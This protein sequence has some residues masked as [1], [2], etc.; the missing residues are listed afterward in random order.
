MRDK[1]KNY[2]YFK[3]HLNY[4]DE[5]LDI[6]LDTS[7]GYEPSYIGLYSSYFAK[8]MVKYSIG[9]EIENLNDNFLK[10]IEYFKK[11]YNSEETSYSKILN[12][13]SLSI[14]FNRDIIKNLHEEI[15]K[16]EYFNDIIIKFFLNSND[17]K[18]FN[19]V[20][21]DMI[22]IKDII[23]NKEDKE[24]CQSNIKKYLDNWY[25][26]NNDAYWY[27]RHK[28]SERYFGYWCLEAAAITIL[29]DL[30]DK[31]YSNHQ[32]YPRDFVLYARKKKF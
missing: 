32:Y 17:Y 27:D 19:A 13:L 1:L 22:P 21:E 7:D 20:W 16:S 9:E 6:Y 2:E 3:N 28:E 10:I 26:N 5:D 15:S 25:E 4:I 11:S 8:L 18:N 30:D 31:E 29:L 23:V 12:T 14:I 24:Y